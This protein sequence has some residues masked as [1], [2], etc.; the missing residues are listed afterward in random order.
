MAD[1]VPG[2][3][4]RYNTIWHW[5]NV[6]GGNPWSFQGLLGESALSALWLGQWVESLAADQRTRLAE[7]E[8]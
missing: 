7:E 2:D 6:S 5:C 1:V 4:F 8:K 3:A